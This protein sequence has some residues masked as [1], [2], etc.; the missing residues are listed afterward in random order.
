[1]LCS[2]PVS[3]ASD[4]IDKVRYAS[5]TDASVLETEKDLYIRITPVSKDTAGA[6][7]MLPFQDIV[8]LTRSCV[9]IYFF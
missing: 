1:M 4:A 8:R 3:N 9:F 5:L 6:A 7:F 2:L